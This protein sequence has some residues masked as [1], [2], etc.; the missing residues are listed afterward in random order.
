MHLNLAQQYLN[1]LSFILRAC[2]LQIAQEHVDLLSIDESSLTE[3][4]IAT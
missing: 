3:M 1:Q 4:L 2:F